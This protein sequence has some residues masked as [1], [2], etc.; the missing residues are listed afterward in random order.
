MKPLA[1]CL[2]VLAALFAAQGQQ[3]FTGT[4][5]DDVCGKGDHSQMRMGSS[6]GECATACVGAHGAAYVLYDG[7]TTYKLSDQP[8]AEQFAGKKVTVTGRLDAK[9]GTIQVNSM[10][11]AR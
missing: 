5:T 7:K 4:V 3:T 6:D 10:R 2:F 1:S 9:T 8:T 11:A